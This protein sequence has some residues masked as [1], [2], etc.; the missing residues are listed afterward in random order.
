MSD[1]SDRWPREEEEYLMKVSDQCQFLS[2]QYNEIY[3][4][5]KVHETRFKLP[6]II[7]GSVVGMLSFGASQFGPENTDRI[8]IGVGVSSIVIS[9]VSSIE[10]YLKIGETMT[11]SL[12]VATQLKKLKEKIDI[13]LAVLPEHRASSSTV[14][15]RQ[16]H[17]EYMDIIEKAP[18]LQFRGILSRLK[19]TFR[20]S[21]G[22]T[23]TGGGTGT[24]HEAIQQ[25][26]RTLI[27]RVR[28]QTRLNA[29]QAAAG[30]TTGGGAGGI[31][32]IG[33]TAP[34]PVRT[35]FQSMV[36]LALGAR[37]SMDYSPK[38]VPSNSNVGPDYA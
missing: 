28:E 7:L 17:G 29:A 6:V 3:N 10:A 4:D 36:G 8:T 22:P 24:G 15:L 26:F 21:P 13:E 18:P 34:T 37:R 27:D 30:I 20:R 16:C 11:N 25:K 35:K 32:G 14:F 33:E 1:D 19:N 38:P 5:Y 12:V 9:I 23:A 31:G 2:I